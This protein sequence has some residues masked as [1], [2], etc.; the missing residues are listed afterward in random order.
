MAHGMKFSP[1]IYGPDST[2]K[3]I[4]PGGLI[5]S[6]GVSIPAY[7]AVVESF[8]T[9]GAWPV[10]AGVNHDFQSISLTAGKHRIS[11]TF[12]GGNGATGATHGINAFVGTVAGDNTTGKVAAQNSAAVTLTGAFDESTLVVLNYEVSISSTTT[13]Y[14][15]ASASAPPAGFIS[16]QQKISA[17][18]VSD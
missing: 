7:S 15:K 16:G 1:V 5:D 10:A 8:G 11:F 18:K 13:F 17:V 3:V 6:A 9:G 14:L 2:A 4:A 12:T